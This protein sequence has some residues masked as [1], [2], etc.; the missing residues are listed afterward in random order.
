[1]A[2]PD[3]DLA[4]DLVKAR[5]N[6]LPGD[7]SID[8]LL[9]ARVTAAAEE[10]EQKGIHLTDSPSDTLLLVDYTAYQYSARDQQTGM[11][12]WLRLRIRE[13]WLQE[14]RNGDDP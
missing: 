8:T 13:R 2:E 4:F 14:G 9:G 1:M 10:L 12:E 7:T 11:P 6:R 5:L 3:L